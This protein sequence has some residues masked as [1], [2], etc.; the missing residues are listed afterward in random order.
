MKEKMNILKK[1]V[2][3]ASLFIGIG[4]WNVA[5]V[6]KDGQWSIGSEYFDAGQMCSLILA[7]AD[8]ALLP[9]LSEYLVEK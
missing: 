5:R 8:K 2:L 9:D 4:L 7:Y 1:N 3:T 6:N